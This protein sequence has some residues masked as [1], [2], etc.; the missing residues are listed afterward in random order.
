MAEADTAPPAAEFNRPVLF[1]GL[2]WSAI[3]YP[4]NA[5][6]LFLG[7]VLA[8]RLLTQD[9]FGAFSL[10]S[11]I[12]APVAL[13]AQLGL[14]HSLLRR[15]AAYRAYWENQPLRRPQR[16]AGPDM[17]LYRRLTW[18]RLAQF[19]VLDTRQYRSDQAYGDNAHVP[20]PE[21]DDP[22]RTMTGAA[23]E[24]WLLDG[25]RSSRALRPWSWRARRSRPRRPSARAS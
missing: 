5:G 13:V 22:A 4:L 18:G 9:D 12:I 17:R 25:W 2:R 20:G 7:H 3:G 19:D 14:P 6:S 15:A 24:R 8:A 10:A 11:S 23:Q 1:R 21:S 16:P